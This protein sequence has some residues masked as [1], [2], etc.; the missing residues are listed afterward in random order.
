MASDMVIVFF[1]ELSTKGRNIF[2]FIR[3]LARN[4]KESLSDCPELG[5]QVHKDH[6]YIE[7]NGVP[8]ERVA[9][10]LSKVP[11]I[12]SYAQVKA[13]DRNIDAVGSEAVNLAKASSAKTFKVVCKRAD[14]IFPMHSDEICRTV[15]GAVLQAVPGISVDVH[16]P[17]LQIHIYVRR[18][19]IFVYG[20][21]TQGLGGYP[22][23]IAGKVLQLLSGGIDSPV[24]AYRMM[25]RGCKVEC[26]HFAAPPYTSDRV[27]DKIADIAE[28]LN[29][30]QPQI[31]L[32]VVPFTK[33][34]EAI[35][36]AAGT[37]YAI[38]IMR[39]MMLRISAAI[40]RKHNC[41]VLSTG[42]SIG[43]VAS[44]TLT[45]ISNI[46]RAVN[47]TVI[48]PLATADKTEIIQEAQGIGTYE[49]SIR[50]YEDCCTI[51]HVKDPVTAPSLERILQIESSFDWEPLVKECVNGVKSVWFRREEPLPDDFASSIF[52]QDK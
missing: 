19:G 32:Y 50:P 41:L 48:R 40:A 1:G 42:E 20:P 28:R 6:I 39:R 29:D 4:I 22:L 45:S 17:E 35:Y 10:A 12:G 23:G 46:D 43:Q 52:K 16:S 13:V 27:L 47:F 33:L 34:Q 37:S 36:D 7:L 15:G 9:E 18:E 24:A 26:I 51:F 25:R 49:I 14:K 2:D 38:T 21:K 3:L 30:Y 5:Y 44:Q 31:K 8:Y 11:G